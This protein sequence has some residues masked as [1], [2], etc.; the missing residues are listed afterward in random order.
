MLLVSWWVLLFLL[1]FYPN[2][3]GF[4]VVD[5]ELNTKVKVKIAVS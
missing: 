4:H 1:P 3:K 5:A 2:K